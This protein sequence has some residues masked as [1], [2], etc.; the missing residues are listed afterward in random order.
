[1]AKVKIDQCRYEEL[2]DTETREDVLLDTIRTEKFISIKEIYL[3]LGCTQD[4]IKIEEEERKEREER[5][6]EVV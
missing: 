1:M 2:L 3:I 5:L 6:D 4:V